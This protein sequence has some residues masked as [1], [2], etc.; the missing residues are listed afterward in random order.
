MSALWQ[1]LSRS[2][3][4]AEIRFVLS[5]ALIG[6]AVGLVLAIAALATPRPEPAATAERVRAFATAIGL[7]WWGGLLFSFALA[8]SARRYVP[9]P[10]VEA[11]LPATSLAAAATVVVAVTAHLVAFSQ[12]AGILAAVAC[13]AVAARLFLAWRRRPQ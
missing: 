7:G 8:L 13:G 11:L 5:G 12:T 2:R 3:V 9:P 6:A 10:E 1:L 4:L